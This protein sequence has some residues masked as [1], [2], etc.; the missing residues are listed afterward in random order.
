MLRQLATRR[1]KSFE[2]VAGMKMNVKRM[3]NALE[4]R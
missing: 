2:K 1:V 3:S 4:V